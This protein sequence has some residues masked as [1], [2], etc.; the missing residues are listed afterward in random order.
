M[1]ILQLC[2][3]FP[4]PLKDGESIAVTYLAKAMNELGA[5]VT[6]LTMN[7]TKHYFDATQLP[8]DFNHY[9]AIY[10]TEL[11]N[12]L[13]F[14]GAFLNLFSAESYHISRFISKSFKKILIQILEDKTF[15]IIQLETVYLAPYIPTIRKYSNAKICMRSHNVEFEI[16]ERIAAN[17]KNPIKKWYLNHLA[18]KLKKFEIT[19]LQEYDILAPITDRDAQ[20]FSSYG[21]DGKMQVTPIGI[22]N[23]DYMADDSSFQK[24]LSISFIGSLD[25]MPNLEGLNYFLNEIW[26]DIH[27]TYPELKFYVAGRNTPQHLKATK[28]PG[29][30]FE[31]EVSDAKKFI[32]KHSIM[33]VPILSGSGMRAKILEGMALGK[34]VL[35]TSIGLEG[36]MAKHKDQVLIANTKAE[37]LSCIEFCY[38]EKSSLIH[39]GQRAQV[40]ISKRYDNLELAKRLLNQ[41]K[42]P[43]LVPVS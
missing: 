27:K 30:I 16:W 19:Q 38:K 25:W 21:F 1:R 17:S 13:S 5:D 24:D 36:I 40:F 43:T 22:D 7:T 31:G 37:F 33:L 28:I 14:F 29:V 39:I 12:R 6:L 41:Y 10:F 18:A 42:A 20:I 4:F 11:D 26:P 9:D 35:T 8:D 15:D 3:K 23:R 32:N 34:V 2:K